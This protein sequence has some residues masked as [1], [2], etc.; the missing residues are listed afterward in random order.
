MQLAPVNELGKL[1]SGTKTSK[2]QSQRALGIWDWIG[3]L[4]IINAPVNELWSVRDWRK[5]SKNQEAKS[6]GLVLWRQRGKSMS[7]SEWDHQMG[8]IK[9]MQN[10]RFE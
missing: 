8:I 3:G 1:G 10:L 6:H 2:S 7:L 4:E 5:C 9:L